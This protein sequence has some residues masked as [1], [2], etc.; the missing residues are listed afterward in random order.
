MVALFSMGAKTVPGCG[1]VILACLA[2]GLRPA[3]ARRQ[4]E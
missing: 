3:A 1:L 4:T 2:L